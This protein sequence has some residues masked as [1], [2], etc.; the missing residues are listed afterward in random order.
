M[1]NSFPKARGLSRR[2]AVRDANVEFVIVCEG[3]ITEPTYFKRLQRLWH[4]PHTLLTIEIIGAAGIPTSVVDRAIAEREDRVRK[5]RRSKDSFDRFE[6]WVAF[7]RDNFE[8]D[9]LND[10]FQRAAANG[11]HVAFSNPCFELWGVFHFECYNRPGHHH[12]IHKHLTKCLPTYH[13][14]KNPVVCPID[15][16]TRYEDAVKNAAEA[17]RLRSLDG[18]SNGDPSTTVDLL[19]ER[20]RVAAK[21]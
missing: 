12:E 16:E 15:L 2:G 17:R 5:N 20:L 10:A 21:R 18:P 1:A 9:V 14:E 3:K 8:T 13:H 19:T 6:V 11:I 7:D 4:Y